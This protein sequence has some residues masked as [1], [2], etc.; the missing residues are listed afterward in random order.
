MPFKAQSYKVEIF[1]LQNKCI[2]KEIFNTR[3]AAE[4]FALTH[5]NQSKVKL[6]KINN[7]LWKIKK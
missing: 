4:V 1:N 6:A 7:K 2:A 5:F 3:T